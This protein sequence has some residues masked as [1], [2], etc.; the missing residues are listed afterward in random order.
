VAMEK[1]EKISDCLEVAIRIERNGLDFYKD[2]SQSVQNSQARDTFSFLAAAEE[3]HLGVFRKMLEEVADY[4]PRLNYPG[5]YELYLEGV[6]SRAVFTPDKM[7]DKKI[8]SVKDISEAIALAMDFETASILFY[9]ELLN[10]FEK[11]NKKYVSEIID[12]EKGHFAKLVNIK[13]KIKF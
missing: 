8:S 2:L 7:Q 13:D 11:I 3:K 9:N 6:A 10:N 4:A 5:E 12:E 1:L